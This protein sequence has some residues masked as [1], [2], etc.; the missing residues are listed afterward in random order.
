VDYA[1]LRTANDRMIYCEI[2]G[3]GRDGPL[4]D[5]PG[6][7]VMLQAFSGMLSTMGHPGGDLV[8]VSFSPVDQ[9]TA[10]HA[11]AGILAA[12]LERTRTGTGM[13]LEVSLLETAVSFM[14]YMA[15]GYWM[16]GNLPK[17]MGSGHE[18]LAPY[19]AFQAADGHVLIGIGNDEQ[20]RRFC[21]AAGLADAAADPR[22]ARNVDRVANFG[23][24]VQLVQAAVQTRNVQD[25][26][27]IL[28]KAKVPCSPVHTLDAALAHPQVAA[29]GLVVP[30]EHTSLGTMKVLAHPVRFAG[31]SRQP[32]RAPPMHGEHTEEVL[33]ELGRPASEIDDLRQRG[34]VR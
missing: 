13:Y 5:R 4:G 22:F 25:W 7:D 14:Q 2:S 8:R 16:T 26:M 19:Q 24:T 15:Q 3:Y 10:Q 29:R 33:R 12:L 17:R 34:I 21:A 6:Y 31:V 23:D 28:I 20:W 18:L 32:T 27:D 1:T 30:V 11:V 9:G